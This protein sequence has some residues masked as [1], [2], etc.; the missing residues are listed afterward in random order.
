MNHHPVHLDVNYCKTHS[1]EKILVVG[2]LVFSLVVG[3]TVSTISGKAIA[4]LEYEYIKHLA[5]VSLNDTIYAR[6]KVIDKVVSENGNTGVLYVE[7]HGYNQHDID[8]I[9]FRRRV[10]HR[11]V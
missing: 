9:S 8:V 11:N 4:N 2:P 7:T 10:L 1:H 3:M 5:P 6:T